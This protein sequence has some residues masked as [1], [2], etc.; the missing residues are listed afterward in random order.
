MSTTFVQVN[1]YTHAVTYVTDKMIA[2]LKRIIIWSGLDQS[3]LADNWATLEKGL[4]TWLQSKDLLQVTLE[5]FD[6]LTN[7]P[8][9]RWDLQVSYS[10]DD[11]DDGAFW[12]D[13]DVIK[14]AIK[15]QGLIPSQCAYE[16]V[17]TTKPG[18]PN[19]PGWVTTEFRST[20]GFVRHSIGTA[21][22]AGRLAAGVAYWKAKS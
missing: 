8:A 1:T 14:H 11:E 10:Y 20:D 15:K 19:V 5:I 9:G 21:I 4:K 13:T 6:P 2:S 16:F 12:V 18:R 22:G 3:Q 7:K 17:V